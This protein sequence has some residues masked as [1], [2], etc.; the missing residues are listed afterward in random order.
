MPKNLKSFLS[1]IL[2]ISSFVLIGYLLGN[3]TKAGVDT[4][5]QTLNRSSLTPPDYVFGIVWTILYVMIAVSG[6]SIWQREYQETALLKKLFASQ[7]ILNWSWTPLFFT[8]HFIGAA[9]ACILLITI[10]VLLVTLK[11]YKNLKLVSFLFA[12]YLGWVLFATYLN[13]YIW[14]HN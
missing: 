11:A 7:M 3:A 5:Y 2:W 12:P 13:F 14:Q 9:L 6:W 8:Y 10:L 4:W 1:L